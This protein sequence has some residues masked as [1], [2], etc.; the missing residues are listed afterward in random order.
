[1]STWVQ[2]FSPP[3]PPPTS[4]HSP[5][6]RHCVTVAACVASHCVT[7]L[8]CPPPVTPVLQSYLMLKLLSMG[9]TY[10]SAFDDAAAVCKRLCRAA[11][12]SVHMLV[13]TSDQVS[14]T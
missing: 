6:H 10:Y 3:P 12:L 11:T 5:S 7:G 4:D 8:P 2:G 1:M 13:R 9:N 14:I